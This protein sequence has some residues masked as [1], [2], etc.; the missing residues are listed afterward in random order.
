VHLPEFAFEKNPDNVRQALSALRVTYPVALDDNFV[1]WRAFKN[2]YWP[3]HYFIDTSGRIRG[4]HLGEG[5]CGESEH[6]IRALPTGA[7]NKAL[8]PAATDSL[9]AA[10]VQAA[11]DDKD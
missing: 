5:H 6:I 11:A 3:A 7:G 1:I 4:H 10:G 2:Q 8:P 9:P